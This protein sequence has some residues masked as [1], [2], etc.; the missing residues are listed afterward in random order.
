[1]KALSEMNFDW[2][3]V[4]APQ[5]L[6]FMAASGAGAPAS[7]AA[8][9]AAAPSSGT[10]GAPS[11]TPPPPTPSGAPPT[12]SPAA[13]GVS[14]TPPPSGT[15]PN[16]ANLEVIRKS[17]EL[18]QKYGGTE[19]VTTAAERYTQLYT[20]SKDLATKL[21]YTPESFERAFGEDPAAI[22]VHLQTES[23]Q[24]QRQR[25]ESDAN[26][27]APVRDLLNRELAPVREAQARQM[28][29]EANRLVDNDFNSQLSSH[30][31]FKDKTVPPEV[32][33]DIYDR[34]VE[35]A[36]ADV[37]TQNAILKTGDISGLKVH[38]DKAVADHYAMVNAHAK[39]NGTTPTG[40][41][42]NNGGTNP[43]PTTRANPNPFNLDDIIEGNDNATAGLASMRNF[44]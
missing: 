40:T 32:R 6:G 11:G 36:V 37:A 17:H 33:N 22:A 21:G 23:R 2:G 14:T 43:P 25:S 39:W 16:A 20:S 30:S 31:L 41:T 18:V 26:I 4:N 38:F 42:G 9:P 44:R 27:P 5:Y 24:Q 1:M 12:A 19:N 15:D 28:A 3:G 13:P 29:Q 7:P 34:F 10:T 8:A 35:A